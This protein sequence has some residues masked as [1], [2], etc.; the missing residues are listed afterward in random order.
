ME[1]PQ[2]AP[3]CEEAAFSSRETCQLLMVSRAE[4]SCD[5]GDCLKMGLGGFAGRSW[6]G[7][8]E[9]G[10][11]SPG[12]MSLLSCGPEPSFVI[13]PPEPASPWDME[14]NSPGRMSNLSEGFPAPQ[15]AWEGDRACVS[16]GCC[17][18]L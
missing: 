13:T 9:R 2:G 5:D 3:S 10:T 14:Q 8:E 16:V 15:L 7:T 12:K 6:I 18:P 17:S 1:E 4:S 11:D